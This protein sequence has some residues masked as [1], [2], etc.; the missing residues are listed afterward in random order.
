MKLNPFTSNNFNAESNPELLSPSQKSR[1]MSEGYLNRDDTTPV[2]V[3]SNTRLIFGYQSRPRIV[4]DLIITSISVYL[5]ISIPLFLSFYPSTLNSKVTLSFH[6]FISLL[7]TIDILV[8][9]RTSYLAEATSEEVRNSKLIMRHYALSLRFLLDVISMF[10][11]ELFNPINFALLRLVKIHKLQKMSTTVSLLKARLTIKLVSEFF[12]ILLFL[13]LFI[14]FTACVFFLVVDSEHNWIPPESYPTLSKDFYDMKK[15][16]QYWASVYHS[17]DFIAGIQNGGETTGQLVFFICFYVIGAVLMAS[18]LG[19]MT[20]LIRNMRNEDKVFIRNYNHLVTMMRK[21]RLP[22]VIRY[23]ITEFFSTN[24][25]SLKFNQEYIKFVS[26]LPPSLVRQVNTIYLDSIIKKNPIISDKKILKFALLRLKS[27]L[28]QP[29]VRIISQFDEASNLYFIANGNCNVE[30][31]DEESVTSLVNVLQD[32]DHFGEISMLFSTECTATV[33]SATYTS[34]AYLNC[35]NFAE[36]IDVFPRVP[37][38]MMNKIVA[39]D[40]RWRVFCRDMIKSVPYLNTCDSNLLIKLLFSLKQERYECGEIIVHEDD[41]IDF[42]Y[43][44]A[45]GEV[46]FFTYL[47]D[48]SAGLLVNDSFCIKS[49]WEDDDSKVLIKLCTVQMG[50]VLFYRQGLIKS[51][52]MVYLR[53]VTGTHLFK[54]PIELLESISRDRPVLS[55]LTELYKS[56]LY[57]YDKIRSESLPLKFPLDIYRCE[58]Y[59]TGL[60]GSLWTGILKF[61]NAVLKIVDIKR[62]TKISNLGS[63]KRIVKKIKAMNLAQSM[64]RPDLVKL[65]ANDHIPHDVVKVVQLLDGDELNNNLLRQFALK[66]NETLGVCEFLSGRIKSCRK[67]VRKLKAD[68]EE[69]ETLASLLEKMLMET[70]RLINK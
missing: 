50:S 11:Y 65:I 37:E 22:S 38:K 51:H 21:L 60:K 29:G 24:Y 35:D 58:K 63:I 40:D 42:V 1:T 18:L 48:R 49:D 5:C 31:I 70:I 66:A 4:W 27:L 45:E 12:I 52:S 54:L 20:F 17:V 9:F 67:K 69:V 56:T 8:N 33:T 25:N 41:K 59:S 39:Y 2:I 32:G 19:K 14:H 7:F 23:K 64:N 26:M 16:E 28:V 34:L 30:V 68:Y 6:L 10:P 13:L 46:E 62:R 15:K 36:L 53:A 57:K 61:K 55:E 43:F 47:Y 3:K 44:I